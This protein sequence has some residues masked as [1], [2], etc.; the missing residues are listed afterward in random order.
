M[1]RLHLQFR[2]IPCFFGGRWMVVG[3]ENIRINQPELKDILAKMKNALE[4]IENR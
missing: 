2:K 1:A 4:V 3:L